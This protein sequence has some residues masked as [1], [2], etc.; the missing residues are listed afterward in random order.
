MKHKLSKV[1]YFKI[2]F[3]VI[4]FIAA[5]TLFADWE[6]FKAELLGLN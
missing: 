2:V 5:S 1:D 4:V 3:F 6:H